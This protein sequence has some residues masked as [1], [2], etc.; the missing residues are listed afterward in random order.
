MSGI[1]LSAG[2]RQNLLS[3]QNTASLLTTTQNHLAT[4]KKVNSAFDNPTSY[5]T[6]QSLNNR[7][8][9]LNALLDQIGQATQTLQTANQGLTSI[10][11]LLQQALSTAQQA[12]QAPA[13]STLSYGAITTNG[14]LKTAET[15][16]VATGTAALG[17]TLGA[18][19]DTL[20]IVAGGT[21]YSVTLAATDTVAAVVSQIN[22]TTGLGATGAITASTTGGGALVLTSN[23]ASQSFTATD[24]N[25]ETNFTSSARGS[26]TGSTAITTTLGANADTLAIVAG[27]STYS[28]TLAATDTLANVV[29]QINGTAGLGASGAVTAS[30]NGGGHLVLTASSTAV[31]FTA[32]DNNAE[33]G[34]TTPGTATSTNVAAVGSST[35]LLQILTAGGITSGD[36]LT[37]SVSGGATQQIQFGTSTG[38]VQTLAQLQSALQGLS[39]ISTASASGSAVSLNV[40][41]SSALNSLA[42]GA[43]GSSGATEILNELGLTA[44][45]VSGTAVASGNNTTRT[46]LQGDFNSILTQIDQLAQDTSYN[47]VNLLNGDNLRVVFDETNT[48]SLTISGVTD[49]SAGL[50]LTQIAGTGFQADSTI[51]TTISSIQ[52]ALSNV[53]AQT[54]TFGTNASTIQ[55][56]QSFTQQLVNVLQTG[57]NNLVLSDQNQESANLL[58]LQ[59]QQ[60]LEIS[61]LSIANQANQ[62]VLKLFS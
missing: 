28:V 18:S 61:A 34:F 46:T 56:R 14:S 43:A 44:G 21:T 25:G 26:V 6:S 29:S 54:E 17:A 51:N 12:L 31:S 33:A 32:S 36:A 60:Q 23:D 24:A 57:A 40:A 52:A 47:G 15:L 39:G 62:S 41:S 58:T 37:F 35:D 53:Q 49:S 5:F 42:T 20:S 13:P 16:G 4:G 59:T 8:N 7:A 1:T 30:T 48:S 3:L 19:N 38:Q 2:V 22:S 45:T 50:G 9:S 10:T 11:S 27:A 55:I